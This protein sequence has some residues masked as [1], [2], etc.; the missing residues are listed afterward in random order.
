MF[1]AAFKLLTVSDCAILNFYLTGTNLE[2]VH[3]VLFRPAL[4]AVKTFLQIYYD[5]ISHISAHF[6]ALMSNGA[7][8]PPTVIIPSQPEIPGIAKDVQTPI[9]PSSGTCHM[10][11]NAKSC[12]RTAQMQ[13]TMTP[14]NQLKRFGIHPPS[15][16]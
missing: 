8:C 9:I 5:E 11:N 2:Y 10:P 4:T 14:I 16:C 12:P 15:D 6:K 1:S 3:L 7:H 13:N